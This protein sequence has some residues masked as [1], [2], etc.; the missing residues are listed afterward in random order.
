M[1]LSSHLAPITVGLS[2]ALLSTVSMA[3]T[4][5]TANASIG[6]VQYHLIDLTPNDEKVA[7]LNFLNADNTS[8]AQVQNGLDTSAVTQSKSASSTT[9]DPFFTFVA[10][11]QSQSYSASDG[12]FFSN[13]S[14][15]GYQQ[16]DGYFQGSQTVNHNFSLSGNTAIVITGFISGG[17]SSAD[18]SNFNQIAFSSASIALTQVTPA[19]PN[20]S[21]DQIITR[22]WF[23]PFGNA[24]GHENFS[25]T[26]TN[27][28]AFNVNLNYASSVSANGI[29][30]PAPAVPEPETY[31]MLL[32]GL[33]MLAFLAR[34]K[35]KQNAL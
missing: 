19:D 32:S 34:R 14:T 12:G 10:T 27:N 4:G 7:S 33:G 5:V 20:G 25:I 15:K 23:S 24:P 3:D 11:A 17:T 8:L 22:D 18:L 35:A 30:Q 28:N 6:N 2:I 29:V 16:G 31:A 1:T 26:F 13:I 21:F 9:L